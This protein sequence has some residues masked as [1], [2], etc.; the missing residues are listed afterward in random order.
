[1]PK[2]S[3]SRGF[4]CS[5]AWEKGFLRRER[6]FAA[7]ARNAKLFW[8]ALSKEGFARTDYGVTDEQAPR[9]RRVFILALAALPPRRA[10]LDVSS[11]SGKRATK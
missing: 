9:R 7:L 11:Y 4:F 3:P 8:P 5:P 2:L 10:R 1:M 6:A